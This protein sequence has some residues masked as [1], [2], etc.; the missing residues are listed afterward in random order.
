[1]ITTED[2]Q[3]LV[4][5]ATLTPNK[6]LMIEKYSNSSGWVYDYLVEPLSASGYDD[7]VKESHAQLFEIR[8]TEIITPRKFGIPGSEV[9]LHDLHAW[10]NELLTSFEKRMDTPADARETRSVNAGLTI[11]GDGTMYKEGAED[12]VV[13]TD[14]KVL[15]QKLVFMG[16]EGSTSWN[17]TAVKKRIKERLPIGEYMGRMNLSPSKIEDLHVQDL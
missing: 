12:T 2:I 10:V 8:A 6:A 4:K 1:M 7:L 15:S 9:S 11:R 16:K 5:V 17:K 14:L 3:R 13:I